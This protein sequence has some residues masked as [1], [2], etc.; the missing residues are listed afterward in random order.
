MPAPKTTN[1]TTQA[2]AI[3]A[4]WYSN[5]PTSA[6]VSRAFANIRA[7]M[8]HGRE[9]LANNSAPSAGTAMG[10]RIGPIRGVCIGKPY[11]EHQFLSNSLCSTHRAPNFDG[12]GFFRMDLKNLAFQASR[13]TVSPSEC[14]SST[15][16]PSVVEG[17][18]SYCSERWHPTPGE[19]FVKWVEAHLESA[20]PPGDVEVVRTQTNASAMG[21]WKR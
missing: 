17:A 1:D 3:Y 4:K 10:Q 18:S 14:S 13:A 9:G 12:R 20:P 6:A 16:A 19:R 15:A 21:D 11:C 7:A 2:I 5:R 8:T